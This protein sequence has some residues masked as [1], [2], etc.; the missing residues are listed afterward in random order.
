MR[1][2]RKFAEVLLCAH[3]LPHSSSLLMESGKQP[4]SAQIKLS[5]SMSLPVRLPIKIFK[6]MKKT[7]LFLSAIL[8]AAQ[9]FASVNVAT[10]EDVTVGEDSINHNPEWEDGNQYWTSGDFRFNTAVAYAGTYYAG[11]TV[12]A[13]QNSLFA[14]PYGNDIYFSACGGAYEGSNFA[15]FYGD[16]YISDFDPSITIETATVIPGMMLTNAAY[17]LDVI[18]NGNDYARKFAQDDWFLLTITGY[19]GETETGTIEYFL[20][21]Y[22]SNEDWTYAK[23]WQWL[24]LTELG[25]IDR[26]TFSFTSSDTG[27]WGMNTPSLFC[28]DNFG[29]EKPEKVNDLTH[30]TPVSSGIENAATADTAT[31][32]MHNGEVLILRN[33]KTFDILGNVR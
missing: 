24:D 8:C 29:C 26:V 12:S 10:F 2:L 6:Q 13:Y 18:L 11:T 27:D 15:T 31:K 14:S 20:A 19:K 17:L 25:E 30:V 21:D 3:S 1:T 5:R 33:G 9:L 16:A 4:F 23:D 28:I 7:T 32:I 22:R